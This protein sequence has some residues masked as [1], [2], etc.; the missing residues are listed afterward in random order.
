MTPKSKA[1]KAKG[2]AECHQIKNTTVFPCTTEEI[3]NKMKRLQCRSSKV[4]CDCWRHNTIQPW[5][6]EKSNWWCSGCT[7]PEME[8]GGTMQTTGQPYSWE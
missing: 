6:L 3:V 2:E 7:L 5:D 8:S 1:T 4:R